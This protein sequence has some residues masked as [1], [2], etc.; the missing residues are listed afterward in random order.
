MHPETPLRDARLQFVQKRDPTLPLIDV[1]LHPAVH[2]FRMAAEFLG[3]RMVVRGEEADAADVR[4]DMVQHRLGDRDAVVAARA[5]AE[6]V[7]DDEGARAGF[8]EDLFGFGELNE[9]GG[10]CGEDVVVG[11]EA[12]HDSVDRGEAGG[13]AGEVEADLG[14]DGG[15]AGLVDGDE[16]VNS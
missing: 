13:G 3:E 16:D 2:D 10:L 9:E 1:D 7:E 12:G 4:G 11:A 6:L 5:A 15:D 8:G 14:H